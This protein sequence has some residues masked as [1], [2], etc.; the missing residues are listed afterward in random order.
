MPESREI[1]ALPSFQENIER[2]SPI[3]IGEVFEARFEILSELGIGGNGIVYK[4]RHVELHT[5]VAIKTLR[6]ASVQDATSYLRFQQEAR[7]TAALKHPNIIE[8]IDFGRTK[9]SL[10]YLVMEYLEGHS[11][12]NLMSADKRIGLDSFLRIFTQ[13]CAGLQHAHKKGIVHRDI[14]PSNLMLIDTED[15]TNVVKIVDFGLAK[16]TSAQQEQS[17]T[18]SGVVIGTPLFMSPEQCR[19][20]VL[21]N[22][23]DIY[24]LGCVM[25]ATLTGKVPFRGQSAMDTLFRHMGELPKPISQIAPELFIPGT[26]ENVVMKALSKNPGDRQQSM[27]ELSQ[28]LSDAIYD[29]I[30]TS[31]R[32]NIKLSAQQLPQ[33]PSPMKSAITTSA[34]VDSN[35]YPASNILQTTAVLKSPEAPSKS[36]SLNKFAVVAILAA[37]GAAACTFWL[38]M[39]H[40]VQTSKMTATADGAQNAS[41]DAGSSNTGSSNVGSANTGSAIASSAITAIG[42]TAPHEQGSTTVAETTAKQLKKEKEDKERLERQMKAETKI[43]AAKMAA[44]IIAKSQADEKA[45]IKSEA[46]SAQRLLGT[47]LSEIRKAAELDFHRGDYKEAER[48][49][50]QCNDIEVQLYARNLYHVARIETLASIVDCL[51]RQRLGGVLEDKEYVMQA[52]AP[53]LEQAEAVYA[54]NPK[55]VIDFVNRRNPMRVWI[56]LTIGAQKVASVLGSKTN[57]QKAM[58]GYCRDFGDLAY[59]QWQG[60]K[61]GLQYR[62]LMLSCSGAY[63]MLNDLQRSM[64]VQQ[65]FKADTGTDLVSPESSRWSKG[66]LREHFRRKHGF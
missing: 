55:S 47:R 60:P 48:E 38:R 46:L 8:I 61:Q 33:I 10:A 53:V 19:G 29:S 22:R 41:S 39:D 26:L 51:N 63:L 5:F 23:S 64:L 62:A 3:S 9:E 7:A 15:A 12:E 32:Q 37:V 27:S 25:Y 2:E 31:T 65:R 44:E 30:G 56:P 6:S 13:V 57:E 20:Y 49:F 34:Q 54:K 66:E 21:D 58:A 1:L 36:S 11:L 45:K 52:L 18:Q 59:S 24:S 35:A 14:K 28:E 16:M 50:R 42:K 4:A 17:L 43:A 40:T